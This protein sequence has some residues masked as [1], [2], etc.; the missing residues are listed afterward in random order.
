MVGCGPRGGCPRWLMCASGPVG[1]RIGVFFLSSGAQL[2]GLRLELGDRWLEAGVRGGGRSG[3][4]CCVRCRRAVHLGLILWGPPPSGILIGKFLIGEMFP[5]AERPKTNS[6]MPSLLRTSG[7]GV[8]R[9]TV[10]GNWVW[11]PDQGTLR[12]PSRGR[13][14]DRRMGARG[15]G[16]GERVAQRYAVAKAGSSAAFGVRMRTTFFFLIFFS[17]TGVRLLVRG[18]PS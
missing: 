7:S 16:G 14:R 4:K 1:L 15:S 13:D 6:P 5:A 17:R 11:V 2:H 10:L 8:S 18:F 12:S 3:R 9:R